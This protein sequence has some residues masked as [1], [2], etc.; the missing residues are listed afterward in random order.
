MD[1]FLSGNSWWIAFSGFFTNQFPGG[2]NQVPA[3]YQV[4]T[5]F[6]AGWVGSGSRKIRCSQEVS[7]LKAGGVFRFQER[8]CGIRKGLGV[9]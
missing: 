6:K 2:T 8:L 1:V 9:S 7:D 3:R 4:D 5:R